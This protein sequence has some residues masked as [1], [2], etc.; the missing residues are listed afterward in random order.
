MHLRMSLE[1]AGT[2]GCRTRR[3]DGCYGQQYL[4]EYRAGIQTEVGWKWCC[5]SS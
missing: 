2:D 5:L 3:R 1:L 4:Q